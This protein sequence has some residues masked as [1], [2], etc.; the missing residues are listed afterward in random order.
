MGM[1]HSGAVMSML[2]LNELIRRNKKRM[3]GGHFT[4]AFPNM[5]RIWK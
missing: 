4:F 2:K 1:E 5:D 3:A